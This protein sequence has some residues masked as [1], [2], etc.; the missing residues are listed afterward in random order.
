[1]VLRP[2]MPRKSRT[3]S[4]QVHV[5]LRLARIF[6]NQFFAESIARKNF[7]P[8]STEKELS[9]YHER[10]KTITLE[11]HVL[12]PEILEATASTRKSGDSHVYMQPL[13]GKLCDFGEGRLADMDA[14]GISVQVFSPSAAGLELLDASTATALVKDTNDKLAAAVKAHPTRFAA[15]ATLALQNPESAAAEFE[16]CIRRLGFKGALIN[17]MS[18]GLFLDDKK[19]TP[20]FE[21]AQSLDVPIYLHPGVPPKPVR[22]IY[23]ASLPGQLGYVL[24]TAGFGW[25]AETAVHCLRLILS[26]VFDRFPNLKIIIGHMGEGLPFSMARSDAILSAG[27]KHLKQRVADYFHQNFYITTSGFFTVPPFLCALEIVGADRL[28]F[29]VDYPFSPNT[30]GRDFLN[31]LPVSPADMEKIAHL[32]AEKLLKL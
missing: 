17:G 29:S 12:T 8:S 15:F 31:I 24:S 14:A 11:E 21:A 28:L 20:I 1:M 6:R 26:G 2:A 32:N 7:K 10:M 22:E 3:A 18:G 30:Q 25:H 9:L 5:S 19:F 4:P 13:L 23:Y 16:R 27:A